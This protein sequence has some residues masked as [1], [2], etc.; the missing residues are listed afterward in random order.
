MIPQAK[1]VLMLASL[2]HLQ[3]CLLCNAAAAQAAEPSP[4][5]ITIGYHD[6]RD[7]LAR[8][9]DPD[10]YAVTAEH[11]AAHFRWLAAEKFNVI[12]INDVLA[13]Q[14]GERP[15]PERSVLLT[16]DD[17]FRSVYTHVFP[18]LKSFGFHA[19]VSPV[20]SWIESDIPIPYNKAEL[21]REDFLTWDQLR[22][23]SE[24]GLVEVASHSHN[25]HRGVTA[26]PQGNDQPAAT[27]AAFRDGAYESVGEYEARVRADLSTS[28]NLIEQQLGVRPRVITWPYGAWNEP[29]RLQAESLGMT[30]SLTLDTRIPLD[31]RGIVGREMPVGNP[32]LERFADLF[33]QRH[34]SPPV[35]AAQVDLDYVYDPDPARQEANLGLLLDRMKSM[36]INTVF[37]QAFADPDGDGAADAVYFP[38]RHLPVRADLFNRAAWQLRTRANVSVYAWMPIMAFSSPDFQPAW[39]VLELP[40]RRPD[41]DAEP[42]LS[43]FVPEVRKL[44]LEI[45]EDLARQADF[46]G[47]HFHDDGRFNE[48]ED[49]NPAAIAAYGNAIGQCVDAGSLTGDRLARDYARFKSAAL[50]RF[51][52]ALGA[53]TAYWHPEL[54]TSRNLFAT[55]LLLED[56]ETFLAQSFPGYLASYDQVTLMAMP[57]FEGYRNERKFYRRLISAVAAEPGGLQRTT[58][59]LQARDWARQRWLSG[60]SLRRTMQYLKS[61]GVQNLAYYPDD[62]ITGQPD[63]KQLTRALSLRDQ[64]G[65]GS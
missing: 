23:M 54:R 56:S 25:M 61:H 46:A 59:Q 34:G 55:A 43:I 31:E 36:G 24:S 45:Y 28:A 62:F 16:F 35:R 53:R 39:Q 27:T 50:I 33:R 19:V 58:F 52:Q 13:A 37:L 64:A 3:L 15:L 8:Y 60:R 21:T 6:V 38:N 44:I 7:N 42:R 22:E 4:G 49:A 63:L 26:N 14:A 20:T 12:S 29:A 1:P 40:R 9:Y 10:Q 5:F 41:P 47:L 48:F 18:L 51:T 2:L 11:L 30:L 32:G 57:R 17:G 65:G